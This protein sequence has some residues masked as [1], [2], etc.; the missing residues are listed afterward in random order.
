M[1]REAAQ[2]IR[3]AV[4]ALGK[5]APATGEHARFYRVLQDLTAVAD[6][7]EAP[8]VLT[9]VNTPKPAA[10]ERGRFDPGLTRVGARIVVV[11][12]RFRKAA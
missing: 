1:S 12:R 3:E 10:V 11:E 4:T 8:P 6:G 9:G 2:H 7:L 5:I